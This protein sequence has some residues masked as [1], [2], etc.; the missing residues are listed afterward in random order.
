M[1]NTQTKGLLYTLVG[2]MCWGLSGC[3]GEYLFSEKHI[4]A[5]WLVNIR[6]IF[7]GT[8][9]VIYSYFTER[10][11][12][13]NILTNKEDF[14]QLI[15]FGLIGLMACQYTYFSAIEHSNA[16][17]A[18]V[19]QSLNPIIILGYLCIKNKQSPKFVEIL[20]IIVALIGIFLL[21]T[22]GDIHN[23][24][25]SQK[26]LFMG[27]M[28]AVGAAAYSLMGSG[29]IKK[30][31]VFVVVGFGMFLGGIALLPIARIWTIPVEYDAG[32]IGGTLAVSI[33][34]TLIAFTLFLKGI[35][36]VGSFVGSLVG[37]IEPVTAVIVSITF[38]GARFSFIEFIGFAMILGTVT[39]LSIYT[40]KKSNDENPEKILESE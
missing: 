32:V 37:M 40:K 26:G 13:K 17:T 7:A 8:I 14:K 36:I 12:L 24:V 31:S 1:N 27:L 3:F 4:T 5:I 20:A 22:K 33:V 23:M 2:G 39:A 16:G 15:L 21:S 18:T 11:K 9:L 25:L 29:L 6:L 38:L 28:S 19:L 34:G 35:S 10:D 30:Y